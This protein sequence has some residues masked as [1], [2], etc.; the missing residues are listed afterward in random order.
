[1]VESDKKLVEELHRLEHP[2]KEASLELLYSDYL[3]YLP[4]NKKKKSK[5]THLS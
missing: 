4:C 1:M 2:L 5:H 3:Y